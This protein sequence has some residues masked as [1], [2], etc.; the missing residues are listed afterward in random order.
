MSFFRGFIRL[1]GKKAIDKF[2]DV[3][4]L[5]FD[6]VKNVEGYAGVLAPE[7]VCIDIDDEESSQK[8][9]RIIEEEDIRCLV[10]KTT[11]GLH[12]FFKND[13]SG[14]WDKCSTKSTLA[15]G[16]QADVKVGKSSSYAVLKK[17]GVERQVIYDIF[18]DEDYQT[19][20]V[21]LRRVHTK[22]EL[23]GVKE[24]EGRN[25]KLFRYI[26]PLQ[27]AGFAKEDIIET[28]RIV[29]LYLFDKPLS[30]NEFETITRDEAFKTKLIP[31]F[32]EGKA[33]H[34][35]EFAKYLIREKHIKRINGALHIYKD[36]IYQYGDRTIEKAMIEIIPTLSDQK[37][38]EVL[39]YLEV[40]ISENS[41]QSDAEYIAFKN[42]IL[43]IFTKELLPFSP[44][45]VITNMIPWDYVEGAKCDLVDET[46][47]K[48]ACGDAQIRALIEEMAGYCFYRRNELRKAFILTGE[49]SNGKST[50]IAM[51]LKLLGEENTAS[52]DLKDLG[53]RFRTE[54]IFRKLAN[55][56]DDID[57]EFISN[58]AIF[59][60]LVSGDRVTAEKKGKDPFE[61]VN[62][63]KF[64]FSANTLPR[65]K[66][67]T[68]A[69]IDRLIIIP[70]N[71]HFSKS[72][73]DFKPFLKYELCKKEAIERLIVL[74]VEGLRRVLEANAFTDS[75]QVKRELKEYDESNN[76]IL[77]FLKELDEDELCREPFAHWYSSY[78]EFCL[79]N[80]IQSLS[81]I[82][83]G[84][85][86]RRRFPSLRMTTK[87]IGGKSVKILSR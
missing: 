3:D 30:K 13:N 76:P 62:Y 74:G 5:S 28:L 7:T 8:L 71:A 68:G 4:V 36:G 23:D 65:V 60:K 56:G 6:A 17:D 73:P 78:H 45:F 47:S 40:L 25:E 32:F 70:F 59:K 81:K 35:D 51:L 54:K 11:R 72:D 19:P 41:T 69:V 87:K 63:A 82:E 22:I 20:P 50:F 46:I 79:S 33:F 83:F 9:L 61:F 84:K 80:Q 26:M 12:F 2:K 77:L 43:N 1:K 31:N 16:I 18:E 42:G 58:T 52:L 10:S 37:R 86:I 24:G 53:D 39:K 67:R 49:K 27:S 55:L 57:D 38:K 48:L 64:I 66:D 44:E 29:N 34:F 85:Q 75:E 14:Y 15:I 21:W